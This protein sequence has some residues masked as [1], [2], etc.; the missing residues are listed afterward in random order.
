MI[1]DLSKR[2]SEIVK[3]AA[4]GL[5]DKAIGRKLGISQGTMNTYWTRVRNKLNATSRAE[6]VAK[7]IEHEAD[8]AKGEVDRL[9]LIIAEANRIEMALRSSEARLGAV[10][11]H[12]PDAMMLVDGETGK[13]TTVNA[14]A[15][16]LSGYSREDL[17][18]RRIES[19]VPE[20]LREGHV[21]YRNEYSAHP[22]RRGMRDHTPLSLRRKDGA[23]IQV[24]I[25]LSY[26]RDD[27]ELIIIASLRDERHK[28]PK[29]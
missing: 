7:M 10:L 9:L 29:E 13:I 1:G 16:Q 15:E 27:D 24:S 23:E 26:L 8:L 25:S 12:A 19:I 14:A 17:I 4:T 22:R 2:E 11:E 20:R 5:T 3:L 21:R 6:L 28:D 18:G